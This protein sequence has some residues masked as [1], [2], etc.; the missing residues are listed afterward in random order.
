MVVA[1]GYQPMGSHKMAP[2]GN[3]RCWPA[4]CWPVLVLSVQ[5]ARG[6]YLG[7]SSTYRGG[8]ENLVDRTDFSRLP[9][10][11]TSAIFALLPLVIFT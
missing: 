5:N 1:L 4:A 10:T 11:T 7:D 8:K 6:F 2:R 3:D 9:K